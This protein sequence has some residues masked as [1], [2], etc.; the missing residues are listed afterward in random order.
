MLESL[1]TKFARGQTMTNIATVREDIPA[2]KTDN[3]NAERR[4]PTEEAT[5]SAA[6]ATVKNT[7]VE[8][9]AAAMK[10]AEEASAAL[11]KNT[12]VEETAVEL[13]RGLWTKEED[14]R[15]IN[16]VKRLGPRWVEIARLT[17]R[18]WHQCRNRWRY[19]LD[20]DR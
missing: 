15:I 18:T 10:K 14:N 16:Y 9:A 19:H 8:A 13:R 2:M 5:A 6:A 17:G 3:V 11:R 12:V 7:V 4:E 1:R 20:P